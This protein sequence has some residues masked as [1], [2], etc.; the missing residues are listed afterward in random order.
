ME[1]CLAEIRGP[2]RYMLAAVAQSARTA[3]DL[4]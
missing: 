4:S 3:S 1:F 2:G